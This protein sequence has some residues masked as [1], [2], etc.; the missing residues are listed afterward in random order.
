MMRIVWLFGL[1]FMLAACGFHLRGSA[2]LPFETLY[3]DAGGSQEIAVA[4]ERAIR[5]SQTRLTSNP[6]E[7]Q[8]ILHLLSESREKRILSLNDAGRVREFQLFYRVTY[9]MSDRSG[10][11]LLPPRQIELKRD[12]SFSDTQLLAKESEEAQLYRDMQRDVVQ[13]ILRGAGAARLQP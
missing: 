11:E 8:V 13:Q 2:S 6:G 7:A 9:R 3:I 12:F 1:V 5:S 4:L 10:K